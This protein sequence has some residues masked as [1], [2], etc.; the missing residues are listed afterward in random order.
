MNKLKPTNTGNAKTINEICSPVIQLSM[1]RYQAIF[2]FYSEEPSSINLQLNQGEDKYNL[3]QI[4]R[5]RRWG[6]NTK[7]Y[8]W[9]IYSQQRE[10]NE[11]KDLDIIDGLVVRQVIWDMNADMDKIKNCPPNEKQQMIDLWPAICTKNIFINKK[12]IS[13]LIKKIS[14][15][16]KLI[17][18]GFLINSSNNPTRNWKDLEV[19]RLFNWGQIHTT[20]S[21][22]KGNIQIEKI[23]D[24]FDEY[25]SLVISRI[26]N[27]IH[28]LD[29]DYSIKPEIYKKI[30]SG[31]S[32][33]F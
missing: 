7:S 5:I 16:D 20:W 19:K 28:S 1:L 31:K 2:D 26:T 10:W 30:I 6:N 21:P 23:I 17:E 32:N 15:F 33:G 24:Q 12:D 18:N 3:E 4:L 8:S 27:E 13:Q 25:L 11:N 29:L 22:T 14:E 9:C